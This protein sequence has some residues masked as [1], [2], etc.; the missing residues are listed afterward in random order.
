MSKIYTSKVC[1]VGDSAV[2]KTSL[3]LKYS[4]NTFLD[5]YKPTLGAD[6]IIKEE[7]LESGDQFH[8]YLWDLAGNPSFAILRSYYMHGANGSL[9]CFDLNNIESFKSVN[10]W[11]KDVRRIRSP[12]IPVILVGTKMDKEQLVLQEDIDEFC[13][14]NNIEFI[15]TS[16]KEGINVRKVFLRIIELIMEKTNSK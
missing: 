1:V 4:K 9:I 8:L 14:S 7:K 2:G 16:S 6:F 11:L 13:K 5:N 12:D 3:I 15:K 10:N